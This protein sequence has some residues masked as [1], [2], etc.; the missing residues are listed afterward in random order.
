MFF[1]NHQALLYLVNKPC[2]TCCIVRWFPNLLE[3][4]FIVVVKKGITH[5]QANHLS[6]L[7]NGESPIGVLDNLLNA[8]LFNVEMIPE[9]IKNF[10]LLLTIER[11]RINESTDHNL[12]LTELSKEYSMLVERLYRLSKDGILRLCVYAKENMGYL[13]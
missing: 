4:D 7:T 10:V 11:L 13:E 6:W 8:Y 3:F 1:T 9:W 2:N 12:S 5:Q